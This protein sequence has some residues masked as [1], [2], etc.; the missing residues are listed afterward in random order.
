MHS[1][2]HLLLF[3]AMC[4]LVWFSDSLTANKL[5]PLNLRHPYPRVAS[6]LLC[7]FLRLAHE[8]NYHH[9]VSV[10]SNTVLLRARRERV[11][12]SSQTGAS[13][14]D[15]IHATNFAPRMSAKSY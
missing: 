4:V 10:W 5:F 6:Q 1:T 3:W 7:Q 8:G 12:L 14:Q 13:D 9:Q 2:I 11:R 15:N